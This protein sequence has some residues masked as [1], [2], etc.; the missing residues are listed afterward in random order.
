MAIDIIN[1]G[2]MKWASTKNDY[3]DGSNEELGLINVNKPVQIMIDMASPLTGWINY[4]KG[5]FADK[6]ALYGSEEAA[7]LKEAMPHT[8]KQ[9]FRM[10]I[11]SRITGPRWF[12]ADAAALKA[13]NKLHDEYLAA[14]AADPAKVGRLPVVELGSTLKSTK[15]E[16]KNGQS[17]TTNFYDP[18][19]TIVAWANTPPAWQPSQAAPV[20]TTTPTTPPPT[21][22]MVA[23]AH[24]ASKPNADDIIADLNET[25]KAA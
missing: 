14:L 2:R 20:A 10:R 19:Y 1:D 25:S 11:A 17:V 6:F 21:L 24:E 15:T 16:T 13:I 22:R 5:A 3:V 18:A 4:V 9:A 8:A 7:T 12:T 23:A